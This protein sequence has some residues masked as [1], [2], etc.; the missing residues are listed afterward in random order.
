MS[1]KF[2]G[3]AVEDIR[4]GMFVE[5]DPENGQVRLRGGEVGDSG[6]GFPP[7]MTVGEVAKGLRVSTM[8]VY[9][10]LKAGDLRKV[11]I[12]KHYRVPR[13]EVEKILNG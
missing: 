12:G 8:T 4:C 7:L 13:S 10:M 6:V 9:R 1:D 5:F 2:Y 11:Q 3:V